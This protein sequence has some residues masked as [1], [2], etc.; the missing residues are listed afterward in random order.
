M[1]LPTGVSIGEVLIDF[2]AQETGLLKDIKLFHKYPGGA[3][4]NFAVGLA[5]LGI[6]VAFVGKVGEDSFGSFLE[7]KLSDEGVLIDF[8]VKGD[9]NERTALAFVSLDKNAER[10]FLFYRN[11]A[12]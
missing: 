11:N 1:T 4:A 12:A 7:K 2:I 10:D 3:P 9:N 5:R 6:N 8:L